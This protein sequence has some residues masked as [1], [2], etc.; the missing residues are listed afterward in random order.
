MILG[1][2]YRYIVYIKHKIESSL[3]RLKNTLQNSL[4]E[5]GLY[6]DMHFY[7]LLLIFMFCRKQNT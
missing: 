6:A 3:N 4:V 2:V 7:K 1:L 5:L